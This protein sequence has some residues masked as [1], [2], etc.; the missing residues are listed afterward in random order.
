M[1]M[2]NNLNRPP[3][4]D[5]W[6]QQTFYLTRREA[7]VQVEEQWLREEQTVW[8]PAR[9]SQRDQDYQRQ[10]AELIQQSQD[11][12]R[13]AFFGNVLWVLRRG[14]VRPVLTRT[15]ESVNLDREIAALRRSFHQLHERDAQYLARRASDLRLKRAQLDA[16]KQALRNLAASFAVNV[17]I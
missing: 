14:V 2:N 11:R 12:L 1:A 6:E 3:A 4:P 9:C 13:S 7:D 17:T 16:D 5:W 8:F 10:E 15:S